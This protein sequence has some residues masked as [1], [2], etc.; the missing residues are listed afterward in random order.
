MPGHMRKRHGVVVAGPR[1]VIAAAEAGCLDTHDDAVRTRH[2]ISDDLHGWPGSELFD[3][4]GS[5]TSI[6][7][8]S[9]PPVSGAGAA[10]A[11]RGRVRHGSGGDPFNSRL[12]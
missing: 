3:D 8:A 7:A 5:H 4:Y 1:V 10:M 9:A 6:I 11:G 2:R 12:I